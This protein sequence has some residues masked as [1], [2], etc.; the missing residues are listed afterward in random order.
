MD[1]QLC[2]SSE[3][4]ARVREAEMLSLIDAWETL[5]D[6]RGHPPRGRGRGGGS[7]RENDKSM[8]TGSSCVQCR[9]SSTEG[10]RDYGEI[11]T[12]PHSG[13]KAVDSL[14]NSLRRG[15]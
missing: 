7:T 2:Y 1:L 3:L 11:G 10:G 12:R 4:R 13:T 8:C 9:W 15:G 5:S 14:H 6:E